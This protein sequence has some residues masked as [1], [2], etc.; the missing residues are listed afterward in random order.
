M[1]PRSSM[2]PIHIV[3]HYIK[4]V[5]IPW[6]YST[7]QDGKPRIKGKSAVGAY[8]TLEVFTAPMKRLT[9]DCDIQIDI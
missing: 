2:C 5:A 7:K 6:T 9:Y 3:S 4:W 1:C 8:F